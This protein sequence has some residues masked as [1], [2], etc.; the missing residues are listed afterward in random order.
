MLKNRF[1]LLHIKHIKNVWRLTITQSNK[2]KLFSSL[3][4]FNEVTSYRY[5]IHFPLTSPEVNKPDLGVYQ[6]HTGF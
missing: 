1:L 4:F 3:M 2:P 5:S 6:S